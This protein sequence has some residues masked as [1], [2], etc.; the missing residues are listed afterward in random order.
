MALHV[1]ENDSRLWRRNEG[2]RHSAFSVLPGCKVKKVLHGRT[3]H[4][5]SD[6]RKR[7]H[8]SNDFGGEEN[9]GL[10]CRRIDL[11]DLRVEQ[12]LDL[13]FLFSG[14]IICDAE[15]VGIAFLQQPG[16]ESPA[17]RWQGLQCQRCSH[18]PYAAHRYAKQRA[19]DQEA[20][21]CG[22]ERRRKFEH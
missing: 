6:S 4:L 16:E 12:G 20:V 22:C 8:P 5:R 18:A 11:L 19:A 3:Q 21:Q 1:L 14:S 17:L 9:D 13:C 2:L 10:R 15:S 7:V